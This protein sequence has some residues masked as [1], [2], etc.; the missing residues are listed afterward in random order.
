MVVESPARIRP[1]SGKEGWSGL[2]LTQQGLLINARPFVPSTV[3]RRQA[4][5]TAAYNALSQGMLEASTDDVAF[6]M[7]LKKRVMNYF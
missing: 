3:G 1:S 6:T 4:N 5:N 2:P 7:S